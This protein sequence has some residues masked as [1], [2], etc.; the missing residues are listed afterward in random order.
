MWDNILLKVIGSSLPFLS[1][2]RYSSG[3]P[4]ANF[5]E[6]PVPLTPC[7]SAIAG[8]SVCGNTFHLFTD[9]PT[10]RTVKRSAVGNTVLAVL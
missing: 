3:Y 4:G 10:V 6:M 7:A 5:F 9:L 8:F 2:Q 1:R